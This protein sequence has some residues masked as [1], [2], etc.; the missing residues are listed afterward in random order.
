MQSDHF[1]EFFAPELDKHGYQ[2]LYKKKT[3]EVGLQICCFSNVQLANILDVLCYGVCLCCRFIVE[4]L[5]QLMVV[6]HFSAEISSLM[7]KNM[8][9]GFMLQVYLFPSIQSQFTCLIIFPSMQVEFNKAA[10]SLTEAAIPSAQKK[11]ALTRL[12]KVRS[13]SVS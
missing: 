10:Q 12:L 7:S 11:T 13:L 2:A 4:I 5:M 6:P 1:E 8:R 9:Y 3:A